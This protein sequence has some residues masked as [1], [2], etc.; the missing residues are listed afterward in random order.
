LVASIGGKLL[1]PCG[2]ADALHL[3]G[4]AAQDLYQISLR[5]RCNACDRTRVL[6]FAERGDVVLTGWRP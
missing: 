1:C 6:D 2:H 5:F 4:L 3:M